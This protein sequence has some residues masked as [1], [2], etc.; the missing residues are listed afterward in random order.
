[1]ED[2]IRKGQPITGMTSGHASFPVAAPIFKFQQAGKSGT[3]ISELLPHTAKIVDDIA[4]PLSVSQL[5]HRVIN[6]TP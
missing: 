4:I 5:T 2:H 1:L 6:D 3:W